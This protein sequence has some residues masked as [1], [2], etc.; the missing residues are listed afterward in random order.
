MCGC[1]GMV[2]ICYHIDSQKKLEHLFLFLSPVYM[3]AL[4]YWSVPLCAPW[5]SSAWWTWV[6]E[7]VL[8]QVCNMQPGILSATVHWFCGVHIYCLVKWALLQIPL[9]ASDVGCLNIYRAPKCCEILIFLSKM[10]L[11][12]LWHHDTQLL[13]SLFWLKKNVHFDS[14]F[15]LGQ[16]VQ[17]IV[18]ASQH[19]L[20]SFLR[21]N[22]KFP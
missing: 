18:V 13:S 20:A 5:Q 11:A 6:W 12:V 3:W 8:G 17:L 22:I 9:L 10:R 7:Y 1:V 21:L 2:C 16:W 4:A 19:C 15:Q 14:L